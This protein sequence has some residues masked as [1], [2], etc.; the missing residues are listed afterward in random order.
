[1]KVTLRDLE[2]AQPGQC[3]SRGGVEQASGSATEASHWSSTSSHQSVAAT[4]PS[5]KE[6]DNGATITFR[7]YGETFLAFN[8]LFPA[9]CYLLA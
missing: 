5:F 4:V 1:M 9:K 3:G 2:A 8:V 7:Q 6:R